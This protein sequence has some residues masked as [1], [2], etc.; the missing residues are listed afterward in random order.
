MIAFRTAT[1]IDACNGPG[2]ALRLDVIGTAATG[3]ASYATSEVGLP[4]VC[5]IEPSSDL[6]PFIS[7]LFVTT[8]DQGEDDIA[9]RIDQQ[10]D[11]CCRQN[12]QQVRQFHSANANTTIEC[13]R[14]GTGSSEKQRRGQNHHTLHPLA[15]HNRCG[16]T[17][18][19]H[20]SLFDRLRVHYKFRITRSP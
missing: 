13:P 20:Q 12:E 1:R 4:V 14:C 11:G 18:E 10:G 19:T 15:T 3:A 8:I 2:S 7:R 16:M 6:G 5:N 9:A 17:G